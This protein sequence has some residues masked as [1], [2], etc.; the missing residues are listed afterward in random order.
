MNKGLKLLATSLTSSLGVSKPVLL[1]YLPDKQHLRGF[2]SAL[3]R[4]VTLASAFFLS[5]CC[6][7]CQVSPL[8]LTLERYRQEGQGFK[9]I[10]RTVLGQ[11]GLPETLSQANYHMSPLR[12]PFP[13]PSSAPSV[14]FFFFYLVLFIWALENL[15]SLCSLKLAL[16][17]PTSTV[18][19]SLECVITPDFILFLVCMCVCFGYEPNL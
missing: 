4:A 11:L 10:L 13:T 12:S 5:L 17:P 9:I 7:I 8:N 16:N 3:P 14:F 19:E 6:R 15:K 1:A 2:A 18:L